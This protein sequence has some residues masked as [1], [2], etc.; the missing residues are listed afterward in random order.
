MQPQ[1][2]LED[3]LHCTMCF[4]PGE[5][6]LSAQRTPGVGRP[7]LVL[8]LFLFKGLTTGFLEVHKNLFIIVI[9]TVII[10]VFFVLALGS[11]MYGDIFFF[12]FLNTWYE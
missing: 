10:S 9:C 2:C 11:T 1:V 8:Q 3:R 7:L 5:L 12:L 4:L 6:A